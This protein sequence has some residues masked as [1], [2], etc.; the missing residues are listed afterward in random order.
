MNWKSMEYAPKDRPILLCIGGIAIQGQYEDGLRDDG[1]R[2]WEAEWRV[3][4]VASHGC[5]CCSSKNPNPIGWVE[6]PK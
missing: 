3:E 5:G 6:L 4:S 1:T 2:Y